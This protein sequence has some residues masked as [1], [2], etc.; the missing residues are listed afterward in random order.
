MP[1]FMMTRVRYSTASLKAMIDKPTDRAEEVRKFIENFGG[2][3]HS[4]FFAYG[5]FDAVVITEFDDEEKG[6]AFL[7]TVGSSGA[8][9]ALETTVLIPSDKAMRALKAANE[10]RS[11][12]RPPGG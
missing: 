3:L 6:A 12:Y 9:S 8:V 11:G 5:E 10:N 2:R 7:L 1:H 4:F